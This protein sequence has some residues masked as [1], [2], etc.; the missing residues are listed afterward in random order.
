MRMPLFTDIILNGQKT[1]QMTRILV[2]GKRASPEDIVPD[3]AEVTIEPVTLKELLHRRAGNDT[4]NK[5]HVTVNK[6]PKPLSTKKYTVELNGNVIDP[7][8]LSDIFLKDMDM[9]QL[10]E[11]DTVWTVSD[12]VE[13]P[14]SGKSISV[15]LNGKEVTFGGHEGSILI[16]GRKA[17]L[18]EIV[19]DGDDIMI[20][21][22]TQERPILSN[23]FEFMDINREE[24]VGKSIRLLVNGAPAR[25]TTPLKDGNRVNIEFIEVKN[26]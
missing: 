2:N 24:L 10:H 22:G 11:T 14:G 25:F 19:L 5:I 9:I 15:I 3:R 6:R 8:D 1:K 18:S 12:I 16:N 23:L 20:R 26:A 13:V 17:E 4:E 7:D 21:E